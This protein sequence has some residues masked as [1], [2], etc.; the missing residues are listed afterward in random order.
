MRDCCGCCFG[1]SLLKRSPP[2]SISLEADS[3]R[4]TKGYVNLIPDMKSTLSTF[5]YKVNDGAAFSAC[6]SRNQLADQKLGSLHA[7][8]DVFMFGVLAFIKPRL[9]LARPTATILPQS[10]YDNRFSPPRLP[11]HA[12]MTVLYSR[13]Q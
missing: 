11:S 12:A 5:D 10:R 9:S 7:G 13:P 4:W 8:L 6:P 2:A 3:R 1:S